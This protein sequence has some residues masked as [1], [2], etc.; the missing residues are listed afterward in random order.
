M[1]V[2]RP[3]SCKKKTSRIRACINVSWWGQTRKYWWEACFRNAYLWFRLNISLSARVLR[4]DRWC[5]GVQWVLR[6]AITQSLLLTSGGLYVQTDD[7]CWTWLYIPGWYWP[8]YGLRLLCVPLVTVQ[9][10]HKRLLLFCQEGI[11]RTVW[12]SVLVMLVV[13][14]FYHNLTTGSWRVG[15][16]FLFPSPNFD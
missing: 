9:D 1:D 3:A 14:C 13:C 6:A 2:K 12:N 10:L 5:Q 11:E 16:L 8:V 4:V 7:T 15:S